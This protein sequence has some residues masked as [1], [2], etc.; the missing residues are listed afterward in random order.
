MSAPGCAGP[1]TPALPALIAAHAAAIPFVAASRAGGRLSRL[2]IDYEV[3]NPFTAT[4]PASPLVSNLIVTRRGPKGTRNTLFNGR[5]TVRRPGDRA[6]QSMLDNETGFRAAL[7][8]TFGLTL[9]EADLTGTPE[10]VDRK[11]T[12]GAT[13]SLRMVIL[14]RHRRDEVARC[15]PGCRCGVL[16][17][18]GR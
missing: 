17:A 7:D 12:R 1:G 5:V 3:A 11:G 10:V 6:E 9:P 2:A 18:Q 13:H 14:G 8:S 4:H 16:A 15:Q